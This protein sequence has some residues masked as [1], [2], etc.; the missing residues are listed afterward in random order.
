MPVDVAGKVMA[1][2]LEAMPSPTMPIDVVGTVMA[3]TLEVTPIMA[4]TPGCM[5]PPINSVCSLPTVYDG[6]PPT[7]AGIVTAAGMLLCTTMPVDV[8]GN[9]MAGTLAAMPIMAW[10]NSSRVTARHDLRRSSR[11]QLHKE[12]SVRLGSGPKMQRHPEYRLLSDS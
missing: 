2:T 6:N 8:A 5:D 12:L 7:V 1:G 3:G 10:S 11:T 9:V 4:S